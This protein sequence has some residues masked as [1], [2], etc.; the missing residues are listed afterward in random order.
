MTIGGYRALLATGAGVLMLAGCGA[1]GDDNE[2][3]DEDESTPHGYVEG[4]EETA[5]A[6]WRLVLADTDSGGLHMLDPATEEVTEVGEVPGTRRA[7][8]DGRFV[9]L[10]GEAET[11]VF[12]SGTWTV[13]H[14]DHVHYYRAEHTMV[15][16]AGAGENIRV[17]GD[18][19]V[20]ALT[21][22]D[23]IDVLDR[24]AMEDDGELSVAA[25]VEGTAAL[26]HSAH[27]L[28]AEATGSD[29]VAV[30]DRAGEPADVD[31]DAECAEPTAW[32]ATQRGAVFAC[33]DGALVV[34]EDDDEFSAADIDYADGAEPVESLHHRPTTAVLAGITAD[35]EVQILNLAA[36][37]WIHVDTDTTPVAA[38]AAGEDMPVLVLDEDGVLRSYDPEDGSELAENELIT[39][40][41][42]GEPTPQI[43]IDTERAYINDANGGVVHE[44]DYNDDLRTARTFELDFTPDLMV[45]TGW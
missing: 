18:G 4:A 34:T 42:A 6:Q 11:T 35:D 19:S 2:A 29:E 15:G 41:V 40:P 32:S 37:E 24:G 25:T 27:L 1:G 22:D 13:D 30:L 36:E 12:D 7:V 16:G 9:Y 45:E 5:E 44:I 10:E 14:G 3:A 23:R 31:L 26:T 38:S 17:A 20:T 43:W 33:A 28:V 39:A 21:S 8:T